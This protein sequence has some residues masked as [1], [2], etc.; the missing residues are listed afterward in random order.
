MI[1]NKPRNVWQWLLLFAPAI[2][3]L[4]ASQTTQWW[5]PSLPILHFE[6]GNDRA[7]PGL[8]RALR[9]LEVTLK[10]I[11]PACAL[12]A[13]V[14]SHGARLGQRIVNTVFFFLCLLFG[15]GFLT[16]IGCSVSHAVRPVQKRV[17]PAARKTPTD[18]GRGQPSNP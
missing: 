2:L 15:N 18:V 4:V 7:D 14:L 9:E 6:G 3:A 12:V 13:L 11:V 1:W 5:M 10:I 8:V 17:A 16:V